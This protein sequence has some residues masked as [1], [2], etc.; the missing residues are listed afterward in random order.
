MPDFI[1][2][3]HNDFNDWQ[4]QF[5]S[6][7]LTDPDTELVILPDAPAPAPISGIVAEEATANIV[8]GPFA[9]GRKVRLK[10]T[11]GIAGFELRFGAV[12]AADMPVTAG[13]VV[14]ASEETIATI[15]E[16]G[17]GEYLNVTNPNDEEGSYEVTL[18]DSPNWQRWA[19]PPEEVQIIVD[20]QEV[21]QP[22]YDKWSDEDARSHA[23]SVA[24]EEGREDYEEFLRGFTAQWIRF[25]KKVN[26][27]AKASLSLTVP[28]TEPTAVTPV[29]YGPVLSIDTIRRLLHK[30][31]VA[32]P[33]NP[34]T[35][36]M[37]EGHK[38]TLERFIGEAG[39]ESGDI[40]WKVYKEV[41]RFLV[42]S[43][44]TDADKGKTAYYRARYI[45]TRG[46]YSPY[47]NTL[48]V[49]IV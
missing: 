41:G 21:Y 1:P 25:N 8:Q 3:A 49:G 22:L 23:I 26:D 38:L 18:L 7:V 33:E 42:R 29:D 27:A 45:T 6:G 46:D 36:A 16:L 15:E 24:H 19:I 37:P 35:Q 10:N 40:N 39:L 28:D 11:M 4:K 12:G 20:A 44:F 30:I 17:G 32:D 13:I 43:Q 48:E 31:R 34:N 2:S 14:G 9:P 5:V 47:G